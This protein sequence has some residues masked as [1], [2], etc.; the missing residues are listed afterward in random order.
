MNQKI[1]DFL[2]IGSIAPAMFSVY[3]GLPKLIGVFLH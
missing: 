1:K 2:I 3:F